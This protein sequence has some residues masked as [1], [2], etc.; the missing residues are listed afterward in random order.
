MNKQKQKN[1]TTKALLSSLKQKI[2]YESN[3]KKWF[4]ILFFTD[5]DFCSKKTYT[6]P[7]QKT[8]ISTSIYGKMSQIFRKYAK[9]GYI[10]TIY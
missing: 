3:E 6:C 7:L 9:I 4:G 2:K 8:S 1:L 5:V 10:D